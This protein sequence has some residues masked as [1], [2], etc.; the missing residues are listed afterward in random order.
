MNKIL[1]MLLILGIIIGISLTILLKTDYPPGVNG[2]STTTKSI[3][4]NKPMFAYSSI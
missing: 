1:T 3:L 2:S 4:D